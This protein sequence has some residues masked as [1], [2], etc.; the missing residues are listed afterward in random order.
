MDFLNYVKEHRQEIIDSTIEL[1]RIPSM[2]VKFDAKSQQPFGEHIQKALDFMLDMAK[3]DGFVIKNIMNYA[4]HIEHGKGDEILGILGHLDVVPPGD[5]WSHP[6][7]HPIIKDD[8]IYARG[9]MD[10]KGPTIAAYYA[11]KFLKDLEVPLHKRVRIILGTDEET[12][13]RGINKYL[14]TEEKPTIGFAPDASFPLIYGEKGMINLDL[15]GTY[16]D[17]EIATFTCGERYNVVPD[18]ASCTLN[19]DKKDAF[20]AFLKYNNFKGEIIDKNYIIHGKNAH[21]M[22]PSLGV[23]AAFILAKFLNEEFDNPYMKFIEKHLSFDALG[24]KLNIDFNHPEMKRFTI[25]PGIFVYNKDTVKIGINCRYPKDYDLEKFEKNIKKAARTY[26][27][28][29]VLE[30][31]VPIHYIE[32]DDPLVKHLMTAYQK[33]TNDMETE[34]FTIGGGTYARALDKAVAFGMLMPGRKDVVHQVD[35]YAFIDDLIDATAI[36]MEAIY[37][38]TRK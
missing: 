26:G 9:V 14:E 2:L 7:F 20:K 31:N 34:P 28:K 19:V 5:G 29:Y 30:R 10:D 6:P 15:I 18:Y 3:K 24:E 11:L 33:I 35:E 37:A 4:A 27:L 25:N 17:D 36:Y 32:K 21:A 38:L 23:N 22:Q 16:Q 1:C 8:K 13:W 12:E